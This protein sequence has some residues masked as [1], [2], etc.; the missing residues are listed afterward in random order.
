MASVTR[1]RPRDVEKRRGT[2]TLPLKEDKRGDLGER[3]ENVGRDTVPP[4]DIPREYPREGRPKVYP[5]R[6]TVVFV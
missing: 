1:L 4:T 6:P 3:W 2:S 5:S